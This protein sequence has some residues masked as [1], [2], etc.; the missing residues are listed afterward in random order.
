MGRNKTHT[1][2]RLSG[3]VMEATLLICHLVG[4]LRA[5]AKLP[6]IRLPWKEHWFG[7][8]N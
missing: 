2:R 3:C 1:Q 5:T 4:P 6:P 7:T 8:K